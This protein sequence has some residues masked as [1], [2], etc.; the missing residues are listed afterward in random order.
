LPDNLAVE[1]QSLFQEFESAE[2]DSNSKISQ[3]DQRK[4]ILQKIVDNI[5]K[6]VAT[7]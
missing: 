6:N 2:L 5:T 3:Q 4:A 7:D 1:I